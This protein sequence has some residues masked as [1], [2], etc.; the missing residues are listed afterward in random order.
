MKKMTATRVGAMAF[1][2]LLLASAGAAVAT[3]DEVVD[4]GS[5]NINV[6]VTDRYPSGVLAM[7]VAANETSLTEQDSGDPLVR[8]FTGTLPTVTVT[9]TRA[10]VPD[11]E[12]FVLGTASAF[13]SGT[14]TIGS[15]HLGWSPQVTG[16][17]D[18]VVQPGGDVDGVLDGD[19]GLVDA[20]LLYVNTDQGETYDQGAWSATADLTLK[21]AASAAATGS[22]TSVMTLSLFE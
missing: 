19:V 8:S 2:T 22:Y 7:S 14:N 20:E 10:V 13:T 9:D 11:A 15:E 21:V 3:A 1:G 5:V 12:W 18:G 17:T 4:D 6:E 16:D